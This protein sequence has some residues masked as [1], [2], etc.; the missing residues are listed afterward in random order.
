MDPISQGALGAVFAQASAKKLHLLTAALVGALA[1]MA[2]DLDV[3]IRSSEDPLLFLEY[4]RQFSH[5]LFFIPIGGLLCGLLVWAVFRKRWQLRFGDCVLW[6]TVG[7]A[8]HGLLDNC[9]SYG[10]QLLW[11]LSTQRFSW[12]VISIVDPLFTLP[13]LFFVVGAAIGQRRFYA[14]LGIAWITGY[15]LL[16]YLQH[17]RAIAMAQQLAAARGHTAT[18]LDAKPSFANILVWKTIY[19]ADDVF[20]V[21]AVK[22]GLAHSTVWPGESIPKLKVSRDFPWLAPDSQQARD[23]E[24]FNH[25]SAGFTAVDPENRNRVI[26]IR[27][28]LL[29]Q[30]VDALWGIELSRT[31]DENSHVDFYTERNGSKQAAQRLW[32]MLLE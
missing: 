26:D 28:S 32:Q 14:Y 15:L 8:T 5:S 11:P 20:Y 27:Y 12:D 10:T 24:R 17:E 18:H 23:I 25:F 29:P 16:G 2:A 30:K 1:G 19:A 13:L 3:L 21:D 22:P 6:S 7:Y 9:T 4:H 31:A